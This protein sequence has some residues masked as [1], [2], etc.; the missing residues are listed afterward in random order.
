MGNHPLPKSG[1]GSLVRSRFQQES[2]G[3]G[4]SAVDCEKFDFSFLNYLA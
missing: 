3:F 2:M 4:G 1:P